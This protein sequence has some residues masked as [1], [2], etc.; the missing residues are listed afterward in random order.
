MRTISVLSRP[1]CSFSAF[2]NASDAFDRPNH[3]VPFTKLIKHNLPMCIVWMLVI[4]C[5][6]HTMQV[7]WSTF[8]ADPFTVKCEQWGKTRNL[9]AT[10]NRC[11]SW[12]AFSSAGHSQGRMHCG[13]YICESPTVRWWHQVPVSVVFKPFWIFAAITLL[14]MILCLIVTRQL[15]YFFPIKIIY[16]LQHQLFPT[17]DTCTFS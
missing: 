8:L 17:F 16:S 12:W 10:S 14:N 6:N 11:L 7:K 5:R 1:S 9:E 2:L 15:A 4:W 13:K 3:N